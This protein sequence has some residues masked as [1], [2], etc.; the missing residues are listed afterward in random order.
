M[1]FKNCYIG[2]FEVVIPII[3]S[4]YVWIRQTAAITKHI[5][6]S[7]IQH[8]SVLIKIIYHTF[9]QTHFLFV[10]VLNNVLTRFTQQIDSIWWENGSG[11]NLLESVT[12]YFI[13]KHTAQVL[14]KNWK[15]EA[16]AKEMGLAI[17][18]EVPPMAFMSVCRTTSEEI[19]F[20]SSFDIGVAMSFLKT[21][22]FLKNHF[23][24][25]HY[26]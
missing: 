25:F 19:L 10:W 3:G 5:S 26:F 16:P 8:V 17:A 24:V 20:P 21:N 7:R 14:V 4:V 23:S 9:S 2:K 6:K 11:N 12:M 15:S 13:R 22:K 18:S 1:S